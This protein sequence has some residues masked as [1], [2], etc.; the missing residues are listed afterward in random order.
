[1]SDNNTSI[2][3]VVESWSGFG[4]AYLSGLS[5]GYQE[6]A[7]RSFDL[8]DTAA[9]RAQAIVDTHRVAVESAT[10]WAR[11]FRDAAVA[12]GE[13]GIARVMDKW[14][15][16]F[17]EK[18]RQLADPIRTAEQK[19]ADLTGEVLRDTAKA[20]RLL[21]GLGQAGKV[22][23]GPIAD[24]VGY[25]QGWKEYI[26][27]GRTDSLANASASILAA[28]LGGLAGGL[29]GALLVGTGAAGSLLLHSRWVSVR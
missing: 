22:A 28:E 25:V 16:K 19:L 18:A 26:D 21:P 2:A 23:L 1:M 11:S 14:A 17:A 3:T 10:A 7:T 13:N 24:G 15:D 27:S 12:N 8:V 20:D 6:L 4:G 5:S 29:L 9:K